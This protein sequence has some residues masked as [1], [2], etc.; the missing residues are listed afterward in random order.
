MRTMNHPESKWN[1][2]LGWIVI[3]ANSWSAIAIA[4]LHWL[5][6]D[7]DPLERAISEYVHGSYGFLMTATFFSQS[8]GSLALGACVIRQGLKQ[9]KALVGSLL[10][11][12]SAVGAAV[13][14]I[15]PADLASPLP[16]TSAGAI[17]AAAGI[18]RFLC[19]AIALPLLSSALA[20]HPRYRKVTK[21]LTPLA[22]LFVVT[23]LVSIFVLAN[24]GW[25][26][27]GQR[28]FIAILLIWMT[29]AVFPL[30][31]KHEN[32]DHRGSA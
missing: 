10:L 19:L 3:G 16:L 20:T 9:R 17:H 26:G 4:L 6:P 31:E 23:F 28:G 21:A 29:M 30:I 14:G 22:M 32:V 15:F 7:L 25:F 18:I 1:R 11:I 5:Q 24:I 13:A 12:V 8:L 2:R 27:L